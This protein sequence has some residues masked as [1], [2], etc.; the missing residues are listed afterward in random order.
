MSLKFAF[1]TQH[2]KLYCQLPG[3]FSR[4]SDQLRVGPSKDQ[5]PVGA[6]LSTIVQN[7]PVAHPASYSMGT[8]SLPRVKLPRRG[9]N[10]PPTSSAEVKGRVE[11]YLY[12]AFR[13]P[14]PLLSLKYLIYLFESQFNLKLTTRSFLNAVCFQ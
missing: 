11:R 13:P 8:G 6:R 2:S 7:G 9:V 12:Y 4:Y 10:H 3:H 5:I 1:K 14:W